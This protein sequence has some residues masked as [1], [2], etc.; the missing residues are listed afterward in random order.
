MM[1][2]F[3]KKSAVLTVGLTALISVTGCSIPFMTP[4]YVEPE[5]KAIDLVEPVTF[6]SS[7]EKA[8]RRDIYNA[9]CCE[10]TVVPYV[11]E[12]AFTVDIRRMSTTL[13][14]GSHV[15]AG[16]VLASSENSS[17]NQL[18]E[19]YENTLSSEE[20]KITALTEE[21]GK[22][23]SEALQKELDKQKELYELD[24]EYINKKLEALVSESEKYILTA[25]TSGTV[26]GIYDNTGSVKAGTAVISVADEIRKLIYTDFHKANEVAN[27]EDYYA[28]INGVRYECTRLDCDEKNRSLFEISDPA[29]NVS[30]G[31][32][33]AFM[34]I[35][36][37]AENV[38]SV[39]TE[40]IKSDDS[41]S[42][43]Y[44]KNGA[45]PE[46]RYLTLGASDGF[47]TEVSSG[48]SEGDIIAD[49]VSETATGKTG[50]TE[51]R[52]IEK[53]YEGMGIF[54][55]PKSEDITC[56][57]TNGTVHFEKY[58]ARM[59][60]YV[61][62]GDVIAE[63]TVSGDNIELERL[64]LQLQRMEERNEAEEKINALREKI[65]K[66]TADYESHELRADKAGIIVGL[67]EFTKGDVINKGVTIATVTDIAN[68]YVA[69]QSTRDLSYGTK[70]TISYVDSKR[71]TCEAVG[72][73][74][75]Y[76]DNS[77]AT[78][79]KMDYV[80]IQVAEADVQAIMAA[81]GG[82]G[83]SVLTVKAEIP[84]YKGIVAV[85]KGAVTV[86]SG[87][88]SVNV[89]EEDGSIKKTCFICCG[90]DKE[91]YYCLAGLGEGET[92]CLK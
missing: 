8:A 84:Q 73:V 53:N 6:E 39:S 58:V 23:Y 38:I 88:Y 90:S 68:C 45:N 89:M 86:Y 87:T 76:N 51:I 30:I 28:L 74:V 34:F 25:E 5:R 63:V 29:N 85:P 24:R 41:G 13:L 81:Q 15:E 75:L 43:V 7:P 3:I 42:Y 44:V 78:S 91:V 4:V 49:S 35:S 16:D 56:N 37:K 48:L 82:M 22:N 62:E 27:A 83:R 17:T 66:L 50:T 21:L 10:V 60:S 61:N 57:V 54:F 36:T 92:V 9:S 70:V 52:D 46:K 19:Q 12:Y 11:K 55:Y 20:E 72:K 79:L 26:A 59:Y 1:K 65:D 32:A 33:G 40:L 71:N 18:I 67:P 64:K 69:V 2:R 31:D 47:F 77:T 14:P 80:L